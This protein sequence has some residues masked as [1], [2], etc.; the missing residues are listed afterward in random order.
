MNRIRVLRIATALIL[1]ALGGGCPA[2]D[3]DGSAD[4]GPEGADP[5]H[6]SSHDDAPVVM[7]AATVGSAGG[8]LKTQDGALA[9]RVPSGALDHDVKVTV[10]SATAPAPGSVG[11]VFEIGPTGTQ[12]KQPVTIALKYTDQDMSD[13]RVATYADGAWQVLPNYVVDAAHHTI[14]GDTMHLSPY[15]V[16]RL[17]CTPAHGSGMCDSSSCPKPSCKDMTCG[18]DPGTQLSC[19]DT[20][21]GPVGSCCFVPSGQTCS[22]RSVGCSSANTAPRADT[23]TGGSGASM[24]SGSSTGGAGAP[25]VDGGA[26]A[27]DAGVKAD[28]P[29]PAPAEPP[30]SD[31]PPEQKDPFA[32]PSVDGGTGGGTAAD[33][34]VPTQADAGVLPTDKPAPPPV[35][36]TCDNKPTCDSAPAC[37]GVAG[38][39]RT[40]CHDTDTG[41]EE[42]CCFAAATDADGSNTGLRDAGTKAADGGTSDPMGTASAPDA[43]VPSEPGSLP[44]SGKGGAGAPA[45]SGGS[46]AGSGGSG[47]GT[48]DAGVPMPPKG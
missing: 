33:G 9:V 14:S 13:L 39:M 11:T 34:G 25:A 16:V 35:D 23:G 29:A 27:F 30:P 7:A 2:E 26:Q 12:F 37:D 5:T 32:A 20:P 28:E 19:M 15:A 36:S 6:S 10:E 44:D 8:E 17:T 43:S 47:A 40:A 41:F 46:I 42:T 48:A 4:G 22:T 24:G 1:V 45:D 18:S 38:A 31:V 21:D 3:T